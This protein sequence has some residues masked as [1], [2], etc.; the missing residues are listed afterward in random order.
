MDS[1]LGTTEIYNIECSPSYIINNLSISKDN[2]YFIHNSQ[3]FPR[4]LIVNKK[5]LKE[6]ENINKCV[7][8]L[9]SSEKN[10]MLFVKSITIKGIEYIAVGLYNGFKIW[11]KEGNRLL[12]QISNPNANKDK[13]YAFIC[14]SEFSINPENINSQKSTDSIL[15]ADNYGQLFLIYGSK[16]SWKSSILYTTK[17]AESI[18]S[19][20]SSV[21]INIFGIT[22][23]NGEI[24][25]LKSEKGNCNVEKKITP[26]EPNMAINSLIFSKKDK[27]EF[28]FASG[29]INGEI[30]IISL[31]D[32][33]LKFSINSNLRSVGP[34]VI[35]DNCEIIT[36][37]DDG[38]VTIWKYDEDK[39]GVVL[40]SNYLFED[41]MIV[42]LAYD[43]EQNSIYISCYDFPEITCISDV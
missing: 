22:L 17:N 6:K 40:K 4:I 42:G 35:K 36:G 2:L 14:C 13:I 18:L 25:L 9:N 11:N 21:E 32:Y 39:D 10:E 1:T 5:L 38:Q 8:V 23:D 43:K 20:G 29:F 15:S 26:E 27:S 30:R 28:F 33:N 19:I 16:S 34:M 12:F 7:S 3:S 24:I 41:K 37:S 31:N